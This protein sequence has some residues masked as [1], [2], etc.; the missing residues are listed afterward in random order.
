MLLVLR[1]KRRGAR[2]NQS[3]SANPFNVAVGRARR[4]VPKILVC[5]IV[6]EVVR[7]QMAPAVG[8]AVVFLD[9]VEVR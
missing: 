5:Q 8:R 7:T 9:V 2:K 3:Y 6:D 4:R 1:N